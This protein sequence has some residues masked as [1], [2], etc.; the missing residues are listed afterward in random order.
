MKIFSKTALPVMALIALVALVAVACG[1]SEEE[2]APAAAPAAAAAPAP[3]SGPAAAPAEAGTVT[4]TFAIAEVSEQFGD[5]P[6][7]PYGASPGEL[8]MGYYDQLLVHD[9]TDPLSPFLAEEWSINDAGNELTLKIKQGVNFNTP[10]EFCLL[11]TSPSPRDR[12]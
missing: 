5:Y 8:N 10:E 12:G 11:Y 3:A 6:V 1:D 9:G 7:Q 2:S 4:V